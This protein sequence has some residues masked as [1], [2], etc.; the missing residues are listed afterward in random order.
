M[1]G[2]HVIH[3]MAKSKDKNQ[4]ICF[5]SAKSRIK[6]GSQVGGGEVLGAAM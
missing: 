6:Q 1:K 5:N 3:E 2:P 4:L